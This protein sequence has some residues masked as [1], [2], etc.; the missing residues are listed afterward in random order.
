MFVTLLDYFNP[1]SQNFFLRVAF[2]PQSA[3]YELKK[4]ELKESFTSKFLFYD[5]ILDAFEQIK[6]LGTG[7]ATPPDFKVTMPE[8]YGGGTF[9]IVD[10]S[11]FVDYR[12]YILN[13]Q[14][15]IMWFFF[16]KGIFRSLPKTTSLQG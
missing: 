6:N 16:V 2:I 13:F 5:N 15:C 12:V 7:S 14:R 4:T 8:K 9:S 10:F 11:Y 1:L 3:E